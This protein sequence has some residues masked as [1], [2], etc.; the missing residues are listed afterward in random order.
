MNERFTFLQE[1]TGQ[2]DLAPN[3]PT[4]TSDSALAVEGRQRDGK[5]TE[6]L[7]VHGANGGP[8][9]ESVK[10][11]LCP[12]VIEVP[13]QECRLNPLMGP[14]YV[15]LRSGNQILNRLI[16]QRGVVILA[17]GH[18]HNVTFMQE[19]TVARLKVVSPFQ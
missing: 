11:G 12:L 5:F 2:F 16:H 3:K 1:L 13:R 6:D 15:Q 9:S 10:E 14:N 7:L 18:E 19:V 17:S 4:N 8:A